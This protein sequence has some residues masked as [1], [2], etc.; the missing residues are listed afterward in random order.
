M[1]DGNAEDQEQKRGGNETRDTDGS[2]DGHDNEKVV[3]TEFASTS[4]K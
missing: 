4:L 1:T 2:E 3:A